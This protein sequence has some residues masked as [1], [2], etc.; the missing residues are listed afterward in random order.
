MTPMNG[1]SILDFAPDSDDALHVACQHIRYRRRV[2][3]WS[4]ARIV[5]DARTA[6]GVIGYD[7]PGPDSLDGDAVGYWLAGLWTSYVKVGD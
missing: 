6:L 1:T 4:M 7:V 3:H 2:S 5:Q